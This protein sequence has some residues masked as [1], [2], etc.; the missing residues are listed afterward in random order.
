MGKHLKLGTYSFILNVVALGLVVNEEKI[1]TREE[2]PED[3]K[4]LFDIVL[5]GKPCEKSIFIN[6]SDETND[7]YYS[8][9]LTQIGDENFVISIIDGDVLTLVESSGKLSITYCIF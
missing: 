8:G 9:Y 2:L 6:L 1:F 3:L 4:P 7:T 5:S